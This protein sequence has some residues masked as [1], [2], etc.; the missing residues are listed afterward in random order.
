MLDHELVLLA[1]RD[2][3][4]T[5]ISAETGVMTLAAT[6]DGYTRTSGSFIDDNFCTGMEVVPDGFA[7]NTV[8]NIVSVTDLKI[9]IDED[10]PAE[11]EAGSRSLTVGMPVLRAWENV[12]NKRVAGR[13][14]LREEYIPGAG[15][16]IGVGPLSKVEYTPLYFIH[17][18]GIADVDVTALFRVTQAVLL[19]FPPML[20]IVLDNNDIVRVRTE[21][22]PYAGQILSRNTGA[23]E[24]VVTIPLVART[25]NPI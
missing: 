12:E 24:S 4:L 23:P 5:A 18:E 10:R 25:S 21:P 19:A 6:V 11:S 9:T 20:A 14:Y 3:L 1:L 16:V 7:D 2:N 15:E 17:I 13:W 22:A 8:A